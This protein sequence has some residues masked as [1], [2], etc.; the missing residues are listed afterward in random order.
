MLQLQRRFVE[1]QKLISDA[2]LTDKATENWLAL[3]RDYI[4]FARI[5]FAQSNWSEA[6]KNA[7]LA[8]SYGKKVNALNVLSEAV[9]V[10]TQSAASSGD[11]YAAYNAQNEWLT[12]KDTLSFLQRDQVMEQLS[13]RFELE[14]HE[15]ENRLLKAE[16]KANMETINQQ[17][18]LTTAVILVLA[19][20]FNC[21]VQALSAKKERA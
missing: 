11:Y 15:T 13:F 20:L 14:K 12:L 2:I 7:Q 19:I 3:S 1:S 17:R 18:I 4:I 9:R 8:F 5:Y 16:N 6:Y 21:R 10:M